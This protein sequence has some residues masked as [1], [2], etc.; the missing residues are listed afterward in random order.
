MAKVGRIGLALVFGAIVVA[1][2]AP[3]AAACDGFYDASE[4]RQIAPPK[5]VPTPEEA[6]AIAEPAMRREDPATAVT[7][8]AEAFPLLRYAT[9]D[10]S[11]KRDAKVMRMMALA[12]VRVDGKVEVAGPFQ[13][14]RP[15]SRE[16]NLQWATLIL[17]RLNSQRPNDPVLQAE[18]GEALAHQADEAKEALEILSGLAAKDAE[19]ARLRRQKGDAAGSDEATKRC[20]TMTKTPAICPAVRD[21][22]ATKVAMTGA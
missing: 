8:I 6:I 5:K 4:E 11:L 21:S 14:T 2:M 18:L 12:L 13:A 1:A 22:G 3:P 16:V 10:E 9:P 19:L 20:R 15:R 7:A 17:R